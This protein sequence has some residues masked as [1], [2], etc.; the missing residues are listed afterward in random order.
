MRGSVQL[1]KFWKPP[2]HQHQVPR[3]TFKKWVGK[4]DYSIPAIIWKTTL[5]K[6]NILA[7]KSC[8]PGGENQISWKSLLFIFWWKGNHNLRQC[9]QTLAVLEEQLWPEGSG[10]EII[11]FRR[12]AFCHRLSHVSWHKFLAAL[13]A[14][15]LTLV[16]QWVSDS[17][18]ATFE[19]WH[20]EWLLTLETP[21][22][23]ERSD[24]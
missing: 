17:L 9:P 18:S 6:L 4:P 15:Y 13:A 10:D 2:Q 21:Q 23:F 12:S 24:V 22:T 20:K 8:R 16:S 3:P 5:W 7:A 11:H 19:F 1:S 14:L